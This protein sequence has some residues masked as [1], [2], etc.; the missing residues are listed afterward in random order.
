MGSAQLFSFSTITKKQN[1]K[2]TYDQLLDALLTAGE[3]L[4][5]AG[6]P[7][8][9]VLGATEKLLAVE[10]GALGR[11]MA[12]LLEARSYDP[13]RFVEG[14]GNGGNGESAAAAAG[15]AADAT[16]FAARLAGAAAG[17]RSRAARAARGSEEEEEEED[18]EEASGSGSGGG[19][20]DDNAAATLLAAAGLDDQRT[21]D[22][23]AELRQ[24]EDRLHELRGFAPERRRR[25]GDDEVMEVAGARRCRRRRACFRCGRRH[26]APRR[27]P[28]RPLPAHL[29]AP[30]HDRRP[31]R[32]PR[33]I[34]LRARRD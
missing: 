25:G 3:A 32:G 23:L 19:S 12:L 29:Q 21:R 26:R 18:S 31:R 6:A 33:W 34:R 1:K 28:Q 15:G 27:R 2:Q 9:A 4:K 10:R 16:D 7:H 20:G 30:G 11:S 13:S 8:E 24:Q 14:N 22:A 5:Y 17:R